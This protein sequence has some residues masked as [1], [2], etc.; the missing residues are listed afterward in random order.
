MP[1]IDEE[2]ELL[3]RPPPTKIPY[4]RDNI[5]AWQKKTIAGI[6]VPGNCKI[7]PIGPELNIQEGPA[8]GSALC[9]RLDG[10]PVVTWLG[11]TGLR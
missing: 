5:R 9:S 6:I 4:W 1:L 7:G 3:G 11:T 10:W 2:D 8:S